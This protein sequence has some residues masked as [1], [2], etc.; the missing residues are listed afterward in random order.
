[1]MGLGHIAKGLQ[2]GM[3]NGLLA[4]SV[5]AHRVLPSTDAQLARH[6]VNDII[7]QAVASV[8]IPDRR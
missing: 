8:H 7:A 1:M 3:R 2:A 6:T 4:V 5:L